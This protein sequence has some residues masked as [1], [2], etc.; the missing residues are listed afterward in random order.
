MTRLGEGPAQHIILPSFDG[1]MYI[2][3]GIS[4]CADTV[5]IGEGGARGQG[6]RGPDVA[7]IGEGGGRHGV[8]LCGGGGRHGVHWW[9]GGSAQESLGF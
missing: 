8:I 9:G 3:D 6:G 7:C 1:Y 4:G 2:V 5:D